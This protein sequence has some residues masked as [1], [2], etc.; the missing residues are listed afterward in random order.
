[1]IYLNLYCRGVSTNKV[2]G[3]LWRRRPRLVQLLMVAGPHWF[4]PALPT[5]QS[6]QTWLV[7]GFEGTAVIT[8]A[9]L[10]ELRSALVI[11]LIA[12]ETATELCQRIGCGN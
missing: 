7:S 11:L 1:L 4:D 6:W 2:S 9:W 10:D 3:A 8:V 5:S 12:N